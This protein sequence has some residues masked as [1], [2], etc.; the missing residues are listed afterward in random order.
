MAPFFW[1]GTTVSGGSGLLGQCLQSGP[2][3][4]SR[5]HKAKMNQEKFH[6]VLLRGLSSRRCQR[7]FALQLGTPNR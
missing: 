5:M 4:L 2:L 6:I 7:C 3:L 1:L